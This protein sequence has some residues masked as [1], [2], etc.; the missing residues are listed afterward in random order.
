MRFEVVCHT[1]QEDLLAKVRA[2]HADDR[3]TLQV[4]DVV[5]DLI[6]FEAV[7]D[8]DF[9]RVRESQRIKLEGCL[10]RFSLGT[11][12]FQGVKLPLDL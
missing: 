5:E 4:A 10:N 2:Q 9:Y 1:L 11:L 7:I 8:R 6:D 3:A 12:A